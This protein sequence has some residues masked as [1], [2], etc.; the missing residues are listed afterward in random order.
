[1]IERTGGLDF[2]LDP[3]VLDP[4][5]AGRVRGILVNALAALDRRM[6]NAAPEGQAT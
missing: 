4:K 3:A 1:M 5:D 6:G 2:Y